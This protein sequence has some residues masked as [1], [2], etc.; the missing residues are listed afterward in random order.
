MAIDT[1]QLNRQITY[2]GYQ[3]MAQMYD[4]SPLSYNEYWKWRDGPEY[5]INNNWWNPNWESLLEDDECD[6]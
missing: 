3:V 4:F 5:W 6:C 2:M 1:T